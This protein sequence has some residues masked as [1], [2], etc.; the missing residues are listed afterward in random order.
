MRNRKVML[1]LPPDVLKTLDAYAKKEFQGN[2]SMA[3]YK[4]LKTFFE[5]KGEEHADL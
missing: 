1:S 2:R 5:P 4:I 3:V